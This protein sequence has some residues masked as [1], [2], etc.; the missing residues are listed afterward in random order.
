[1]EIS[2]TVT[3]RLVQEG[4]AARMADAYVKNREHLAPW[5]PMRPESYFTAEWHETD[6]AGLRAAYDAGSLLPLIVTA[7]SAVIGRVTLSGIVRGAFQSASLGYWL[8]RQHVG[9]G[10]MSAAVDAVLTIARDDLHLH[11]VEAA[12]LLHNAASQRVLSRAGFEQIGL[13]PRYLRIAGVWQD[14]MLFQRI[15]EDGPG[16]IRSLT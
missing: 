13:A 15:L 12:T 9:R 11:R 16:D 14:H 5:E 3:L 6:I 7:G 4:D 2:P 1:M 10:L 8:D